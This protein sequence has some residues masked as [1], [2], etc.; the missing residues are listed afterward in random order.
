MKRSAVTIN[1][2]LIYHLKASIATL[3]QRTDQW[4]GLLGQDGRDQTGRS[5]WSHPVDSTVMLPLHRCSH[6]REVFPWTWGRYVC[7]D[8]AGTGISGRPRG[9]SYHG[10]CRQVVGVSV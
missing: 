7:H 8:L 1:G 6:A 2:I 3:W 4:I 10:Y 5:L 9:A